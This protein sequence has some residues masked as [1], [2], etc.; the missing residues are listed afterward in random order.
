MFVGKN[1]ME[2]WD[3]GRGQAK[4]SYTYGEIARLKG[5]SVESVRNAVCKCVFNPLELESVIDYIRGKRDV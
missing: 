1:A 4:F 3:K 5:I 2:R